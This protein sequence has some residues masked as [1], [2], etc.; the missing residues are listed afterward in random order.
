MGIELLVTTRDIEVAYTVDRE[1][2]KASLEDKKS[3]GQYSAN[4]FMN[5]LSVV[6]SLAGEGGNLLLYLKRVLDNVD[7]GLYQQTQEALAANHERDSGTVRDLFN[8]LI[9]NRVAGEHELN[10]LVERHHN[11]LTVLAEA[12]NALESEDVQ[13]IDVDVAGLEETAKMEHIRENLP[14]L[15]SC[16]QLVMQNLRRLIVTANKL[17]NKNTRPQFLENVEAG[18]VKGS[19]WASLGI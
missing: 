2:Y 4:L 14:L 6:I 19:Y 9:G 17:Y 7:K 1:P 15:K 12:Y 18:M 11:E 16:R 8:I 10:K 13:A 5:R 3:P